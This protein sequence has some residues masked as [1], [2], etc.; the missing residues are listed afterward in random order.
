MGAALHAAWVYKK[1]SGENINLDDI[2]KPFVILNEKRRKKPKA[3]N[4]E[5][6]RIQKDMF[7]ALSERARGQ[8]ALQDPFALRIKLI[9]NI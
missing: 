5:I 9:K 8:S 3:K 2:V 6:H 4:M 1:E 7:K